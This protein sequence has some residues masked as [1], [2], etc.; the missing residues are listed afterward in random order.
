MTLTV[1]DVAYSV[2][3]AY[4]LARF[5]TNGLLYL[6]RSP[7]GVVKSFYAALLVLPAYIMILAIR[8]WEPFQEV[9]L[10]AVLVVEGIAY[11]VSWT[12]FPVIMHQVAASIGRSERF[13]DFLGA[14]NWSSVVQMAAYLP[15]VALAE[16][17]ILPDGVG[18]ALVFG[19]MMAMLAY[20]WF[21][22]KT[23]LAVDGLAAAGFVLVDVF[24]SALITDFADGI[25]T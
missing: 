24:V 25:L 7:E 2:F 10:P 5:D 4:R 9:P 8:M 12:A 11:V 3:G 19:V 6:D 21:I 13:L 1:R 14:Y 20:Q 15:P 17:G 16:S 23:T 18:G 22:M